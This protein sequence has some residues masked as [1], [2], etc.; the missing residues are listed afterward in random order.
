[1]HDV[2]IVIPTFRR[3]HLLRQTVISCLNQKNSLKLDYQIVVVDNSPEKSAQADVEKMTRESSV[4]ISY[5]SEPV[6]N[7]SLA[8]NAGIA[9]SNARFVAFIDDDEQ[10]A[11]DWLDNLVTTQRIYEADAVF[12]PVRPVFERGA[13]P[14][15]DPNALYYTRDRKVPTGSHIRHGSTSNVL[16]KVES[17]FSENE[18]FDPEF[19]LTGGE[20]TAF[21]MRLSKR[22]CKLVWCAEAEV[23]EFVP[24]SRCDVM[25]MLR[26]ALRN[27][28]I[29]V[30]YSVG[31]SDRPAL[32]AAYWMFVGLAQIA[33]FVIPCSILAF[34]SLP[35]AVRAKVKFVGAIG[36]ISWMKIFRYQFYR[37]RLN[38]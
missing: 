30:R 7:I 2:S 11:F 27:G 28:Q 5:I 24:E 19:G 1:M 32:T 38:K 25:Y 18:C 21:F 23:T 3:P 4:P 6:Q 36:K 26:R 16:G 33:V 10:A 35:L 31:N 15:W 34:S 12:G 22:G 8:R 20:D 14:K 9:R 29:F 13:P 37:S 17:C